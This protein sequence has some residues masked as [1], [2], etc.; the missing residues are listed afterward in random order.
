MDDSVRPVEV[1]REPVSVKL[2]PGRKTIMAEGERCAVVLRVLP[3]YC[4]KSTGR[5]G[6]REPVTSF[7][8]AKNS[9]LRGVSILQV[10]GGH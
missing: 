3:R 8:L 2:C 1:G 10:T 9:R 4:G 5:T 7:S 6:Y